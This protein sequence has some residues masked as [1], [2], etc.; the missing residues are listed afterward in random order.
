MFMA[1]AC[2]SVLSMSVRISYLP[3]L[4]VNAEVMLDSMLGEFFVDFTTMWR[5]VQI[6]S[7]FFD[8]Q[9]EGVIIRMRCDM[10]CR[11]CTIGATLTNRAPA[12]IIAEVQCV[13]SLH[14]AW[15]CGWS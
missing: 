9:S 8:C 2:D 11:A 12:C 13:S 5:P 3:V 10:I 14:P 1:T 7:K 4:V 6:M 15:M